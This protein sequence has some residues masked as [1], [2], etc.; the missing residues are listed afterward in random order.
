VIEL[1]T[2]FFTGYSDLTRYL[3]AFCK[4]ALR[5]SPKAGQVRFERILGFAVAALAIPMLILEQMI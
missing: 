2:T 4:L 3:S 5:F 1:V